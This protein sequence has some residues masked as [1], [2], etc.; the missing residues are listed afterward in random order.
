MPHRA[1]SQC[2]ALALLLFLPQLLAATT[3]SAQFLFQVAEIPAGAT[4][5]EVS[6][7]NLGHVAYRAFIPGVGETIG[8][9]DG[10]SPQIEIVR[11]GDLVEAGTF[12]TAKPISLLDGVS[13]NDADEIALNVSYVGGHAV[14]IVEP[15]F[16]VSWPPPA[17]QFQLV[18]D[19][20]NFAVPS[21]FSGP[22]GEPSLATPT[23]ALFQ[24]GL[25][26]SPNTRLVLWDGAAFSTL[27]EQFGNYPEG[28]TRLGGDGVFAFVGERAYPVAGG[29]FT[30]P[31]PGTWFYNDDGYA[32]QFVAGEIIATNGISTN[33]LASGIFPHSAIVK[34]INNAREVV[35]ADPEDPNDPNESP[36]RLRW[37]SGPRVVGQAVPPWGGV[38]IVQEGDSLF[39][40]TIDDVDGLMG[41]IVDSNEPGQMA[42]TVRMTDGRHLLLRSDPPGTS[43]VNPFVVGI[44]KASGLPAKIHFASASNRVWCPIGPCLGFGPFIRWVDPPVATGFD[45]ELDPADPPFASVIVPNPLPGGDGS[46]TLHF[47]ATSVPLEAGVSFDFTSANPAGVLAFSIEDIDPA[48]G[49]DGDTV[50]FVIGVTNM[51]DDVLVTMTITA[52]TLGV[53]PAMSGVALAVLTVA[54]L[55]LGLRSL[56]RG[57]IRSPP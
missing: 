51:S 55:G 31:V 44:T 14:V 26:G 40:S 10:I 15:P 30:T 27:D 35:Y 36:K 9:G 6:I 25:V 43:I 23:G 38:T 48:E 8:Y 54:A 42:F 39:G 4:F 2:L 32:A 47:D 7:N 57:G 19:T 49:V 41:S 50:P 5:F 22:F 45:Y 37:S 34:A 3:V 1:P 12:L 53:V 52:Q 13:I 17:A 56:R 28:E 18:A 24:A 16:P 33:V 11:V 29:P 20:D 21:D 46:F